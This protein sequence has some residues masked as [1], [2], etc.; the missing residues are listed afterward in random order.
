M[1][2]VKTEY[3]LEDDVESKDKVFVLFYASWCPHSQRFL[4]VFQKFAKD[5]THACVQIVTDDKTNLCDKYSV[6]IVPTVLFF[7]NGKVAKRLDGVPGKGL[8]EKQL[9][10]FA[11]SCSAAA[12]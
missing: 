4:P 11:E 7:K 1:S 9:K 2:K 5:K 12:T 6:D 10:E 3:D 8:N